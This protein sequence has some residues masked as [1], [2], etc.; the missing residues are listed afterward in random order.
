[1]ESFKVFLEQQVFVDKVLREFEQPAL[2]RP[3]GVYWRGPSPR[4]SAKKSEIL[5][6]WPQIA[7]DMPISIT[8]IIKTPGSN[9]RSYGEDGI[10]I[11]GSWPFITS[12]LGRL[13]EVLAYE[14]PQTKL[15]L[16]FRA[17]EPDSGT[18]GKQS[19]VFYMNVEPRTEIPTV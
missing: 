2:D 7:Q 1:M 13:K 14:N 11:T 12:V 15:R 3:Q 19:F 16:S 4:W 6:M 9:N 10:R 18:P 8:P 5:Q 17:V